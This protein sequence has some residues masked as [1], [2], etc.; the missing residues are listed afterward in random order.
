[1]NSN[2]TNTS[3]DDHSDHPNNGYS[4]SIYRNQKNSAESANVFSIF[5]LVLGILAILSFFTVY[6]P[7][8]F[9]GLSIIFGILSRGNQKKFHSLAIAGFYTAASGILVILVLLV[10]IITML[11][12]NPTFYNMVDEFWKDTYGVDL[13]TYIEENSGYSIS[14]N[15]LMN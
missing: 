9:G 5:S 1:M 15:D 14:Q 8:I 12:T 2:Q 7:F 4:G 13:D 3:P 10:T 11:F 6:F